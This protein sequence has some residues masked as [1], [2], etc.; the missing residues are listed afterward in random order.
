MLIR[1]CSVLPQRVQNAIVF[2]M[3]RSKIRVVARTHY[4]SSVSKGDIRV[5][6]HPIW[7]RIER[8]DWEFPVLSKLAAL[9]RQGDVV[10]DIGA[11]IG[12]YTLLLSELVGRGGTVVAFEPDPIAMYS[13]RQNIRLGK[14]E[15]VLL[16]RECLSDSN[17]HAVLRTRRFGDSGSSITSL[18]GNPKLASM[19]VDCSTVDSYCSREGLRPTGFKIDA[20]GAETSIFRGARET[21]ERCRP[22]ILLEF[23]GLLTSRVDERQRLWQEIL[24]WARRYEVLDGSPDGIAHVFIET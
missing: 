20:E 4:P 8:E 15:N 23:H 10:L 3:D 7:A 12:V 5:R 13:L 1:F 2:T 16:S 11:W 6:F 19:T 22:W 9:V 14:L 24:S 21:I 18:A 17:G